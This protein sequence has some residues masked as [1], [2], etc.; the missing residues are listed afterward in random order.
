MLK[1][2][3]ATIAAL[4]KKTSLSANEIKEQHKEFKKICPQGVV[5]SS[6]CFN[7]FFAWNP[8]FNNLCL[9]SLWFSTKYFSRWQ[10]NNFWKTPLNSLVKRDLSWQSVFSSYHHFH[11]SGH[12]Q[13]NFQYHGLVV[14][15]II[16]HLRVFDDDKSGTMDFGEFVLATNCTSLSDPQEKVRWPIENR[17]LI[18]RSPD[19]SHLA[20][21]FLMFLTKTVVARLNLTRSSSWWDIVGDVL[22]NH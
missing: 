19:I 12:Q 4:Q 2:E 21:G 5:T 8:G 15:E 9:W 10:R 16:M 1:E 14:M 17:I 6:P 20:A 18:L 13:I 22:W 3:A 11:P 7:H